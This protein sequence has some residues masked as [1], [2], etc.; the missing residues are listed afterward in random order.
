MNDYQKTE[1]DIKSRTRGLFL[2]ISN[3]ILYMMLSRMDE[4]E[5]CDATLE[6]INDFLSEYKNNKSKYL[7]ND[8]EIDLFEKINQAANTQSAFDETIINKIVW[9]MEELGIFLWLFEAVEIPGYDTQFSSDIFKKV[10][11]IDNA[12]LIDPLTAKKEM[13]KALLYLWRY[14]LEASN[15]IQELTIDISII[16]RKRLDEVRQDGLDIETTENDLTLFG[17]KFS[18]L[19]GSRKDLVRQICERRIA[20]L[21]WALLEETS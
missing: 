7:L 12:S 20:A 2:Y 4:Q 1:N 9:K 14:H 17:Q 3:A 6:K 8:H 15:A 10:P 18:S 16:I 13:D 19:P 21:E 5:T 11:Q